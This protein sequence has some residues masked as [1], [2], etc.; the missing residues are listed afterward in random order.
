MTSRTRLNAV[1]VEDGD[2]GRGARA[3]RVPGGHFG[4]CRAIC[5]ST[6]TDDSPVFPRV[7]LPLC[8]QPLLSC[9]PDPL[10]ALAPRRRC[11]CWAAFWRLFSRAVVAGGTLLRQSFR[12]WENFASAIVCVAVV[13]HCSYTSKAEIA[14][15]AETNP[16]FWGAVPALAS[17]RRC[18]R[19]AAFWAIVFTG[20][21]SWGNPCCPSPS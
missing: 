19:W 14:V 7:P 1:A 9:S 10:P 12:S 21:R 20:R 18:G 11:G 2:G 8:V 17:R 3:Y 4:R 15:P 13:T 16:C 5:I 6:T